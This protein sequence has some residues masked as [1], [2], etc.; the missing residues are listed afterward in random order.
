MALELVA[1]RGPDE[2][3][4]VGVE[5]LVHDQIDLAEID[6]AQIDRDFLGIRGLGSQLM[7]N[8]GHPSTIH[9]TSGWMA[10]GWARGGTQG[11]KCSFQ[12]KIR[13]LISRAADRLR[14]T[15]KP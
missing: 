11:L 10:Y 3:G 7:Y 14:A 15:V 13:L 9:L 12:R 1:D 2:I 4:A 6:V 8:I 5:A